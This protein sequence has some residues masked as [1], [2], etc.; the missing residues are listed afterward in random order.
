MP[1]YNWGMEA[2]GKILKLLNLIGTFL[3]G[4]V[5][6]MGLAMNLYDVTTSLH[7]NSPVWPITGAGIF[8]ISIMAMLWPFIWA[9][10]NAKTTL[11][12]AKKKT[13]EL[14][15]RPSSGW[16]SIIEKQAKS[17][18]HITI[19]VFVTNITNRDIIIANV[20]LRKLPKIGDVNVSS[21]DD[22]DICPLNSLVTRRLVFL[23][24]PPEPIKP[25]EIVSVSI[26]FE[27]GM[28]QSR[29]Y[30]KHSTITSDV[31]IFDQY[32]NEHLLKKVEF[33]YK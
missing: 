7:L 19:S 14:G 25:N 16:W 24:R 33:Q 8:F 32:G 27:V 28:V 22:I 11:I 13:I 6:I 15:L 21:P 31:S 3:G 26:A 30:K 1:R 4:I 23:P 5:G 29:I 20:R 12:E 9:A 18:M 10:E 2:W 17:I